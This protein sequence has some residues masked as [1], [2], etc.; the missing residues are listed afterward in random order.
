MGFG[1]EEPPVD[2]VRDA[3]WLRGVIIADDTAAYVIAAL[4]YC[5]LMNS[6]HDE[7]TRAVAVAAGVA[8]DH[9]IVHC[10]HQHDAPIINFEIEPLVR[11]ETFPRAWWREVLEGVACAV[12][13]AREAMV[14]IARIGCAEVR[15]EGYA[16][17][18]RILDDQG[19]IAF[20]R[21]S[22]TDLREL[23]E[24]PTG[25]IDPMLRSVAF[26]DAAGSIVA[27]LSFY[28]THP[29]VANNSRRF[30]AD[31][32]GEALRLLEKAAPG[33]FPCFITGAGGNVT[34]GKFTSYE[35][36]EGNLR[37]F[38]AL[39]AAGIGHNLDSMRWSACGNVALRAS[40]FEFPAV[41]RDGEIDDELCATVVRCCREYPGSRLYRL[42]LLDFGCAKILFFPGE[43]FVEYQLLAQSLV[44][45]AFMAVAG[46]CSDNFLY[47]PMA[48]HF[49]QG[50]YEVTSYRWCTTAFEERF[51]DAIAGLI[52]G[53]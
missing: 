13:S 40:E 19:K 33:S 34:A 20:M 11:R 26:S 25:V 15:L 46:N 42:K 38:G 18:R 39:L 35:D 5:G 32:P 17:N 50:G 10:V 52:R 24:L 8:G 51:R 36:L 29:Q 47:L 12:G 7:L 1:V 6:A 48:E 49:A 9:V 41:D 45:D 27:S 43:P 2:G 4:D 21:F 23:R 31:A 14:E 44:P 3:L 28:A 22:R 37:S 30:S 53:Q 16:S